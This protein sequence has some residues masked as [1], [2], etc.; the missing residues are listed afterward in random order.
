MLPAAGIVQIRNARPQSARDE[1]HVVGVALLPEVE[2]HIVRSPVKVCHVESQRLY[3][4][5]VANAELLEVV[6]HVATA[7][8]KVDGVPLE[9]WA[10]L[11]PWQRWFAYALLYTE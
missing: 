10:V 7:H 1:E 2:V 8:S 4:V 9:V 3:I 5:P 6:Q 11:S